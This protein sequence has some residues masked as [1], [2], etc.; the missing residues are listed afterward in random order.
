[1]DTLLV[2]G[3]IRRIEKLLEN[4]KIIPSDI[5]HIC[6]DFYFTTAIVFYLSV[7]RGSE[8]ADQNVDKDLMC[9]V[10]MD[11]KKRWKINMHE[12][13]DHKSIIT[14]KDVEKHTFD[15]WSLDYTAI[16]FTRNLELPQSVK[17]KIPDKNIKFNNIVFRCCGENVGGNVTDYCAASIFNS[18]EFQKASNDNITSYTWD[19]PRFTDKSSELYAVYST[20]TRALYTIHHRSIHKLSFSSTEYFDQKEWKWETLNSAMPNATNMSSAI[21]IRNKRLFIIP[22]RSNKADIL[23]IDK[24][25][26]IKVS[27][28][29]I[30]VANLC[31]IHY[32]EAN[33]II[34]VGGGYGTR[35]WDEVEFLDLEKDVWTSLPNTNEQHDMY[36]LLWLEDN[37]NLLHIMSISSNCIE[38]IDL[39]EGKKWSI[40]NDNLAEIFDTEFHGDIDNATVSHLIGN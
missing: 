35:A 8:T 40:K 6:F 19:L 11:N 31:G 9:A 5:Y 26:W 28:R 2:H 14:L 33:D 20:D 30:S 29:N 13:N 15:K 3:F 22:G 21:M 25:E 27:E 18:R 7:L 12:L 17:S 16:E 39:R 23:D 37:N 36:P 32:N 38:Y 1:M 10:N 34:Y 24:N 4:D